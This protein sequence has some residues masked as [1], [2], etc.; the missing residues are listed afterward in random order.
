MTNQYNQIST[1]P[2]TYLETLFGQENF[3][4][5]LNNTLKESFTH[6]EFRYLN[7]NIPFDNIDPLAVL[8]LM[9]ESN[10]FQYYWEHPHRDLA[11]AAGRRIKLIRINGKNRFDELSREID[12]LK[13]HCYEFSEIPH[14]LSGIH[15]FGGFSFSDEPL[16]GAWSNFSNASF[17]LPKWTLARDGKFSILSI[18]VPIGSQVD[19]LAIKDHLYNFL[20]EFCKTLKERLKDQHMLFRLG[21]GTNTLEESRSN[22]DKARWEQNIQRARELIRDEAFEKIVLAREHRVL[23]E[24]QI[25]PSTLIHLLRKEYPTCY[26]FLFQLND[27]ATFLGSTPEKLATLDNR[28]LTTEALA[29]SFP[30]GKTASQDAAYEKDLLSS[31]KDL[32]EHRYVVDVLMEN[33]RDISSE[34][35]GS[36]HPG[37]LKFSNVQHLYTP[38]SAYLQQPVNPIDVVRSLHPTPAVGG[39]PQHAALKHIQELESFERGWYAGPVGWFNNRGRAEFA[40]AI[41]SGLLQSQKIRLYSGCG[42]VEDSDPE[43]EWEETKLKLLPMLNAVQYACE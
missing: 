22:H 37:I 30:R 41:R 20:S 4:A 23:S 19:P 27:Q 2:V 40:V 39:Y 32:E 10:D 8:E 12:Q 25:R 28:H 6:T 17:V 34:V 15:F 3:T 16:S 9:G 24:Q 1:E 18:T 13:N 7:V 38:I 42:I 26:S 33:L 29:G 43:I 21:P 31:E 5:F 35:M 11:I 36:G 14:S